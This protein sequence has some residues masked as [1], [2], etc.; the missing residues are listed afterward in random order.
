[1]AFFRP[2]PSFA[3]DRSPKVGVLLVNLGTPDAPTPAAVRRYLGEF[4]SDPRVVE[5]PRV[6]WTPLLH[7]VVLRVRPARSAAKYASI[8]TNDGSPLLVHSTK[9]KVLL[10]GYLGQRIKKDGLPSDLCLVE[11]GM[12]YGQPSIANALDKLRAAHC[13]KILVL[14][15]YPQYAASTTASTFDA[16][17]AHFATARRVP[18]LRF[19]DT[20]H[21]DPGYVAALAAAVNGY[22]EKHGRPN[23]LVL[24]FHGVPKRSLTA[25]D[26]YHCY[27]QITGRLLAE[28]LGLE[29]SQW[30]LSFQSRFGRAEWL[31]PYTFET[32]TTLARE[33]KRRVD[34]FCPGFVADC[35]ETLEEIGIEGRRVFQKAGGAELHAIPCLNE[36]PA[37]MAALTDLAFRQ[38][39]GWLAKPPDAAAREKTLLRAKVAGAKS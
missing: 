29:K 12:R 21:D 10:A 13:E 30:A 7:G 22:W 32:L 20:F 1:M 38:L 36:H 27:C 16:V 23:K 9:Q 8:W 6:A 17:A 18:A 28:E 2:E 39:A 31:K 5:I 26:P 4:L 24:S 37:W 34:I 15:L 11:L 25:G 35:L 33:G 3:H 14:P 19:V